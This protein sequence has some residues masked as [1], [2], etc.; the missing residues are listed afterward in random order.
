MEHLTL[1][2]GARALHSIPPEHRF[3]INDNNEVIL[4]QFCALRVHG[5]WVWTEATKYDGD[6]NTTGE[7]KAGAARA[8]QLAQLGYGIRAGPHM[9]C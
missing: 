2:R 8:L 9:G 6:K 5:G 7:K 1:L 4:T 3:K